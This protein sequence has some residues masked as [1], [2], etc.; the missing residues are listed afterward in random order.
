VNEFSARMI[1][2]RK[3]GI[4]RGACNEIYCSTRRI[5]VEDF[6]WSD[7][8]L[9]CQSTVSIPSDRVGILSNRVLEMRII[10]EQI[11][12]HI[13]HAGQTKSKDNPGVPRS[14]RCNGFEK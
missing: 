3:Y 12:P 7:K 1:E 9:F 4:L 2:S 11:F 13:L 8:L 5:D 10:R 14:A 6:H